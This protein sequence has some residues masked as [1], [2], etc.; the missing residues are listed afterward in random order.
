VER[1]L[2]LRDDIAQPAGQHLADRIEM[3]VGRRR[4]DAG[5]R[6]SRRGHRQRV[7]VERAEL[8]NA[9]LIDQ[10]HHVG[11][12]ADG[13]A[14]RASADRFRERDQ[15]RGD[16]KPLR[17]SAW[18]D[19]AARLHLVED[20][21]RAVLVDD[22]LR[23]REV[24]VVRHDDAQVHHHGLDDQ[25]RDLVRVALEYGFE[26]VEVV[27]GDHRRQ[28]CEHLGDA[29][30]L[31]HRGGRVRRSHAVGLR[32]DGH[33]QRVVM[34]VVGSL[35]LDDPVAPGEATRE[36]HRVQRRFRSAV[37]EA[38][39]RLLETLRELLRHLD[40][41]W[42]GLREVCTEPRPLRDRLDDQR[43]RVPDHH[44]AEPVVEVDVLIAV[45]VPH[46][47][48]LPALD[49]DRLRRRVLE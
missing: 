16:A 22:L 44:D 5:Q 41:V 7:A 48:A 28:V 34:A 31:R 8:R 26:L 18:R 23:L 6:G 35:D 37:G 40:D 45:D 29:L 38:P 32:L 27:E 1:K 2:V 17:R 49:E 42:P 43:V 4:E 13:A 46:A 12:P 47:A 9:V 25:R 33:H 30:G 36:A 21:Q 39:L 15:V 20:Q 11:S 19:G 10:G 24:A 3:R 14:R